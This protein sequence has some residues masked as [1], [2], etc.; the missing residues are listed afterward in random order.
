[1]P[2]RLRSATG[3]ILLLLLLI[4]TACS[5]GGGDGGSAPEEPAANEPATSAPDEEPAAATGD[6]PDPCALLTTQEIRNATGHPFGDAV[7]NEDLSGDAQVICDWTSEDPF[8]TAQV[9]IVRSNL[10]SQRE[11]VES[12]FGEKTVALDLADGAYRTKEGSLV[13]MQVGDLFVQVA[14]IPPG[15]GNVADVT[16][17]LAEQALSRI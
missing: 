14:Y 4:L 3:T 16:V 15:P 12:A 10:E 9:L 11:T 5:G 13:A 6:L 8:A 1:M 2:A 17:G 7:F